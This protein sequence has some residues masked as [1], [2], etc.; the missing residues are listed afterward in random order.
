MP[1]AIN[2]NFDQDIEQDVVLEQLDGKA[3]AVQVTLKNAENVYKSFLY[4]RKMYST[5][6]SRETIM[7]MD[8]VALSSYTQVVIPEKSNYIVVN[9]YST[10]TSGIKINSKEYILQPGEKETFPIIS[11]DSSVSPAIQSDVLELNGS[12][13][14]VIKNIQEY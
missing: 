4:L 1:Q 2:T 3:P 6:P 10:A 5:F 14:Y 11:A 12:L 7:D 9:N 13:S 8:T